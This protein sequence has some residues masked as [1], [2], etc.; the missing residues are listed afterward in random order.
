[1]SKIINKEL[2]LKPGDERTVLSYCF[3]N[4]DYFYNLSSK[5]TEVD[6]LSD[7][8]Q[9]LFGVLKELIS[10]GVNSIDIAMVLNYAQSMGISELIGGPEYI[11]SIA[12]IQTSHDNFEKYLENVIEASTKFKAYVNL[13]QHIEE[14][15]KNA[16]SGKSSSDLI[17]SVE[18]NMLDMSNMSSLI[19]EPIKFGDTL[20]EFIE[21]HRY[22]KISMTGIS[23]GY[24]IL[25]RQIDGMIPGTLM[26][27]AARKKMG[28]SAF[29]TNVGLYNAFKAN[30]PV[31]YIDTELTFKEFETRALSILTG[32]KERDIKHGGYSK[33]QLMKF[34]WAAKLISDGK[35][36]HK[37][38][39]GYTVESVVSLCKKY[40][41]KENMGLIIFDY[42]KEPDLSSVSGDRKEYQLLGDITT[43]LKDVAGILD[44]PVLT[45]VQLNRQNDIADSD[46]IAR[47]G[48]IIS[49]WALRTKDEKEACGIDGGQYKLIIKDT[50]RGGSTPE[51]GIGYFFHKTYLTIK[52]V[53]APDQYFMSLGEEV[54]NDED[55]QE[56][57]YDGGIYSG[58]ELA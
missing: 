4:V 43:K 3:K 13:T 2:F 32:I 39:P 1:M 46:R 58:D 52:E 56:D 26:V 10:S 54:T 30:I 37:Y 50:R 14:F 20:H 29:L 40:K 44:V 22:K 23:T 36:Y 57:M 47:Y 12:N 25:D 11:Q 15:E 31:L 49:S 45:A 53:P 8:H 7:E 21:E 55:V 41:L 48:D 34:E 6:F 28:K 18:T 35:F 19:E 17:N 24:P 27:I 51:E 33:E 38:M 5:L 16:K 42:L 9:M